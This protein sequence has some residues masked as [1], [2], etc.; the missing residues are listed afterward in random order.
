MSLDS[1]QDSQS[2]RRRNVRWKEKVAPK[3][4]PQ[5]N[6]FCAVLHGQSNASEVLHASNDGAIQLEQ[7]GRIRRNREEAVL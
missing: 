4:D 3:R 5:V 1:L 6:R 7:L 2:C